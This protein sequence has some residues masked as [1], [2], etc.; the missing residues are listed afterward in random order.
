MIETIKAF[1]MAIKIIFHN[2][3]IIYLLKDIIALIY[4]TETIMNIITTSLKT[5]KFEKKA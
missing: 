5:W 3:G 1:K 4:W 2:M